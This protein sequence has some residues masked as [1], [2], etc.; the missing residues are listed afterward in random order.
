MIVELPYD[1]ILFHDGGEHN[2]S[3]TGI[4]TIHDLLY[5]K[6]PRPPQNMKMV[7]VL[8]ANFSVKKPLE[9]AVEI[10][11]KLFFRRK[12]THLVSTMAEAERLIS[13]AGF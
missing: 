7:I 13:K 4:G 11:D 6:V 12:I 1:V 3:T 9:A 2:I 10:L 5:N 8:S